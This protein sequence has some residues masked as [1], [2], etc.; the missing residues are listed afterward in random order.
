MA[1]IIRAVFVL[2][3]R[4]FLPPFFC[5]PY[6]VAALPRC[7]YRCSSVVFNCIV[8]AKGGTPNL[9][10]E[11]WLYDLAVN[12]GEAVM[13]ALETIREPLM[14]DP[15]AIKNRCLQIVNVNRVLGDVE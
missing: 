4:I 7:V 3:L 9:L 8:W 12:V 2:F 10:C 14:I 13:A 15:E 11:D 5:P 1:S 6:L